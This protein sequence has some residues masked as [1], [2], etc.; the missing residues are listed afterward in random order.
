MLAIPSVA[1]ADVQR[2][3]EQEAT[4]TVTQPAGRT[5]QWDDV[6]THDFKVTVNPC[7]NTFEGT[8]RITRRRVPTSSRTSPAS[9]ATAPS[10][11]A[12]RSTAAPSS[13]R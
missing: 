2:Y 7:D 3:Q 11:T 4:F 6:F 13:A 5:D 9:S 8:G 1:S 10:A 12:R